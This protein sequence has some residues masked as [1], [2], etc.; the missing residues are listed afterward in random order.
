LLITF[1]Y[2]FRRIRLI[3][4]P[5]WNPTEKQGFLIKIRSRPLNWFPLG[6]KFLLPKYLRLIR[7]KRI[8]VVCSLP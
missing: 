2:H 6:R 4:H 8:P 7:E 1:S 3:E 5:A